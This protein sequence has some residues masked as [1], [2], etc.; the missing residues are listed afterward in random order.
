[1]VSNTEQ[2]REGYLKN[3]WP[4]FEKRQHPF[5]VVGCLALRWMEVN[6]PVSDEIDILVRTSQKLE[7]VDDLVSTG[8]WHTVSDAAPRQPWSTMIPSGVI[9]TWGSI[10]LVN[11]DIEGNYP[12]ALNLWPG[13][14]YHISVDDLKVEVPDCTVWNTLLLEAKYH[15]DLDH[16][17]YGP[18]GSAKLRRGRDPDF[19][20][21]QIS[22]KKIGSQ[23]KIFIPSLPNVLNGLL[24]QALCAKDPSKFNESEY[25]FH[26]LMR[27][28][29]LERP[30]Q[31]DRFLPLL[32]ESVRKSYKELASR[33]KRKL[34]TT[35][36]TVASTT[37]SFK[38]WN[39]AIPD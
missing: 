5:V 24:K 38:P 37:V 20:A 8:C 31:S 34:P 14:N 32:S 22:R 6:D 15:P 25:Q 17:R 9:R 29:F 10:R 4:I 35:F 30:N 27:Y 11:E 23:A 7:L 19:A 13:E 39:L 3:V 26:N 1:M 28:L 12:F 36:D 33:Y 21:I 16:I 18:R 2:T